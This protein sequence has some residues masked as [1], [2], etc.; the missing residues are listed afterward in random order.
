MKRKFQ[1]LIK[2]ILDVLFSP[3]LIMGA[4]IA[5]IIPKKNIVRALIGLS[6]NNN[7][8]YLRDCLNKIGYNSQV[9]PWIIPNHEKENIDYNLN[10]NDFFPRL[11]SNFFGQ[12]L[13]IYC[14]IFKL[15]EC[16]VHLL[17][18]F[19]FSLIIKRVYNKMK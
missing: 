9:I 10:I 17:F 2:H 5:R 4:L 11:Y 15:V 3:L 14:F 7:L 16:L 6:P 13:L 12:L 18:K 19:I 1:L 8:I